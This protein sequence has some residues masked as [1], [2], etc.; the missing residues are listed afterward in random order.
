MRGRPLSKKKRKELEKVVQ[1][2]KKISQRGDILEALKSVQAKPEEMKL[3]T[4]TSDMQS[5]IEKRPLEEEP[6]EKD[7]LKIS[8]V[9]GS[10]KRRKTEAVPAEDSDNTSDYSTDE[11]DVEE[12]TTNQED[13]VETQ[14]VEN[15]QSLS[16]KTEKVEKEVPKPHPSDAPR[17]PTVNVP[18]ER[19]PEVQEQRLKLPILAEEQIIMEAINEN[20]VVVLCGETGSGKT[21]QVPQFLYEA[22]YALN[23][24]QICV[25]EPRR[26]AAISMSKRVAYEMNLS[27][28][29]VSYQIRYEGNLSAD[30]K[31]KFM[32]DGVL[33]KEVQKDFLLSK[34]RVVIIDEAHERS[35]FSDIL[36]GLLSRIVP[37]RHKRGNPLKLVIM[38][39]TLRVE[40]FTA[41]AHLFKVTPPVIKVE[42]RQFP[43]SIHF[44]KHTREDY[45]GEAYKKVCKIHRKLPDGG[46]LVFVTGQQEVHTLCA[47]LKK[48]FPSKNQ[49]YGEFLSFVSRLFSDPS[50]GRKRRRKQS[51]TEKVT[52]PKISLD[53]YSVLP[54]DEEADS[55]LDTLDSDTEETMTGVDYDSDDDD[56][57][58]INSSDQPLYIL[59]MFS[60]LPSNKQQL[61]FD[62]P[63]E[64]SRLCVISTNV[65]ETS[66]TIP[67][68]KYVVDTGKVKSKFYDKV[69]GVSAFRV[70]WTS[71]AAANQRAGRAGRTGPGHCYRLFSSAVFTDF[72][73][74]SPPEICQ[75]PVDDLMLLM[76]DMSIDKVVN[77]P[78]P[79]PPD[80][81]A[82]KAAENLLIHLG[83]LQPA[84]QKARSKETELHTVITPLGRAMAS[85][86][87]APR[88]GKMLSLGQQHKLLPYVVAMVA[89]LSVQEVFIEAERRGTEEGEMKHAKVKLQAMRKTWAGKGH[90]MQ[91]GDLMVLLKAI[92]ASEFEGLTPA[93]CEKYGLRFKA[94]VEIR[95]LRAQLTNTV[96][97][98]LA[99]AEISVDPK[100][101]PPTDLQA[102]LLQ[103]I[104]LSGLA[105]HVA[106]KLPEPAKGTDD[107]K[108]LKYAY[109]SICLD[110]P[111]FIHPTSVLYKSDAEYI[112][113]QSVEDASKL[114]MKGISAIQAEWLPIFAPS[115]CNFSKPLEHPAPRYQLSS[116]KVLCHSTSTCGPHGWQ[117][118]EVEMEFP[119]GVDR[120]KWFGRFLLEGIVCPQLEKFVPTLLTAPLT[121]VKSWA[122]L[123]PRTETFLKALMAAQVDSKASLMAKWQ[124]DPNFLLKEYSEW[125][126]RVQHLEVEAKWPP[127]S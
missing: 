93:F 66:L 124:K 62:P 68:I 47:R 78:F 55:Q 69:T 70:T 25:T 17:V 33:L 27:Q 19:L 101:A 103:Q 99:D 10:N 46:I 8:T 59:P 111:V 71:A 7:P 28:R 63:P 39:A 112:V 20:P 3:F 41:N 114:Y 67:N 84:K 102:K 31:I 30:T 34:Y 65:S 89:G 119:V 58:V 4:S 22:G 48:M 44:N 38:S 64:G 126:P 75:R 37:L 61:V 24:H 15:P 97:S 76:K 105:D 77:F 74:F 29:E 21:T 52:L 9:S 85:F 32:T 108:K 100:M 98:V 123:Q 18:V 40:D 57:D 125:V 26:V 72:E 79:T 54:A 42:S 45:L 60:L 113:Y 51:E 12:T 91:L 110:D 88:Y 116:G 127:I 16:T 5:R 2:K 107:A 11:S 36:L 53:S 109:Q 35:I 118:P 87:V 56:D 50:E 49:D 95:K 92:G 6:K 94:M 115:R 82:L 120:F 117:I 121:M 86:P 106:R 81:E 43:V 80:I 1:R 23:G 73:K 90:S 14:E 96:N 83:A 122:K 13:V 104:V